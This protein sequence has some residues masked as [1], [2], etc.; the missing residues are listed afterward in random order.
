[1]RIKKIGPYLLLKEIGKGASATVYKGK[2]DE[3][4][5]K[6]AIKMIDINNLSEK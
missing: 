4:Y 2:I 3:T 1:M 5:E 6:V